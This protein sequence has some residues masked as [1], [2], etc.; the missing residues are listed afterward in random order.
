MKNYEIINL[1]SLEKK[2]E[3]YQEKRQFIA[4]L[5]FV[6]MFLLAIAY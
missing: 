1:Y 3:K 2:E 5:M 6:G 4:G